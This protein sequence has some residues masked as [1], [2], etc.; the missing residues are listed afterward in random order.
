MKKFEMAEMEIEKFNI[1]DVITTSGD[2]VA[3]NI[4]CPDDDCSSATDWG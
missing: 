3:C 4:D 1:V 2:P